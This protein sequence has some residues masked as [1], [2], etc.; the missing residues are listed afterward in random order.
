MN[1]KPNVKEECVVVDSLSMYTIIEPQPFDVLRSADQHLN[2]T[3]ILV[4][5]KTAAFRS[6]H[7]RACEHRA[8]MFETCS[9]MHQTLAPLQHI[10]KTLKDSRCAANLTLALFLQGRLNRRTGLQTPEHVHVM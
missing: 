9:M 4:C 10:K 3:L 1:L 5:S 7:T 2:D 6:T 8:K